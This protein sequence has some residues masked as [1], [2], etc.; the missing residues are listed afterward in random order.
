MNNEEEYIRAAIPRQEKIRLVDGDDSDRDG[1]N[2]NYDFN[3]DDNYI[4]GFDYVRNDN[5]DEEYEKSINE[6]LETYLKS[7]ENMTEE[8]KN[9]T[10]EE[11]IKKNEK[12][13]QPLLMS[14]QKCMSFEKNEDKLLNYQI[15]ESVIDSYCKGNPI[16]DSM[17]NSI[18]ENVILTLNS[19][20]IP[21]KSVNE[22]LMRK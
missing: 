22:L 17:D 1:F 12:V 4:N 2:D 9:E 15:T 18:Y 16:V 20:R 21:D 3:D 6:S 11:R 13:F 7:V 5:Y 8:A 10:Y 14:L 19:I